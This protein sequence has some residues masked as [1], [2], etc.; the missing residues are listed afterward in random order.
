MTN[1][2]IYDLVA[3]FDAS[4]A[5]SMRVRMGDFSLE[6]TRG[7]DSNAQTAGFAA[8]QTPSGAAPA[9]GS[10]AAPKAPQ[11]SVPGAAAIKAP[12]V[13]TFYAA[14][15]PDRPPLVSAGDKVKK[16]Q[17]LCLIEAMKMMSEIAA[18]C[19]CIIEEICKQNGEMVEYGEAIMRYREC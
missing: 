5:S 14:S 10:S 3:C 16:G 7:A 12:L 17:T 9:P 1:K 8:P 4:T 18:P 2:D 15:A 19:D 6:L 11:G 13:G